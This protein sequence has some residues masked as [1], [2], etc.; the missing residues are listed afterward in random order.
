M[1]YLNFTGIIKLKMI[2]KCIKLSKLML[3]QVN[4]FFINFVKNNCLFFF[5]VDKL[6]SYQVTAFVKLKSEQ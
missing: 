3:Y 5:H 1:E 2:N 6:I 4:A